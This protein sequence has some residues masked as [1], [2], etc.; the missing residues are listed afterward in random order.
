[1]ETAKELKELQDRLDEAGDT[2]AIQV[3]LNKKREAEL[4]RLKK[5]VEESAIQR[6][7]DLVAVRKRHGEVVI[8]LEQ[9]VEASSHQRQRS[10]VD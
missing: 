10:G 4:V 9:Q 8:E 5:E 2:N 6:E 1:M 3:E 7:S